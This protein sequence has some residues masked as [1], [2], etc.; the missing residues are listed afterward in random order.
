VGGG[1]HNGCKTESISNGKGHRNKERTV[2]LVIQE[3]ER[4]IL[5]DDPGDIV[6]VPC[7]IEITR[8]HQGKVSTVPNVLV[9]QR[10]TQREQM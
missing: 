10:V 1:G 4:A 3:I 9:L 8:G 7:I 6:W 5:V 2:S